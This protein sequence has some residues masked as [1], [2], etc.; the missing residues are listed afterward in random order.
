VLMWNGA[1][2]LMH[3][4]LRSFGIDFTLSQSAYCFGVYAIF[5]IVPVQGIAG[6]GTQAAWFALAL[7]AAGY[8][9]DDAIALGFVLHGTFYVFISSLGLFSLFVWFKGRGEKRSNAASPE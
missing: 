5:Q 9:A 8:R 1:V 4:I 6:I 3:L 2:I 7:N